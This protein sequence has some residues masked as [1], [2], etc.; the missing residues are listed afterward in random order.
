MEA[1]SPRWRAL[2]RDGHC[3][4]VVQQVMP[5][6]LTGFMGILAYGAG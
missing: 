3:A 1:W 6:L 2:A 4:R 5:P